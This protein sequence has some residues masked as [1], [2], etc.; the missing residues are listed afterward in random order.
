MPLTTNDDSRVEDYFNSTGCDEG[1][2]VI[3]FPWDSG[4]ICWDNNPFC[5]DDVAIVR[6]ILEGVTDGNGKVI[7]TDEGWLGAYDK[8]DEPKKKR[9]IY[10]AAKVKGENDIYKGK[11][12][13]KDVKLTAKDIKLTVDAV[14]KKAGIKIEIDNKEK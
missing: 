14:A 6:E 9:F 1:N 5:W 8:L 11:K 7:G 2:N 4:T 12:E 10:L 3:S 13:V